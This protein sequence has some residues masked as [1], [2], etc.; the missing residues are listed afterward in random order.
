MMKKSIIAGLMLVL[1]QVVAAPVLAANVKVTIVNKTGYTM[2]EFYGSN[3]GTED[4][5]E[6]ILGEY[7][8]PQGESLEVDFDDGSGYCIFDFLAVFD[9]GETV[10]EENVNVCEVGTFTFE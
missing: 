1:A 6:D 10:K 5:Q 2:E 3:N 4:W 9:N 7:A 8:L